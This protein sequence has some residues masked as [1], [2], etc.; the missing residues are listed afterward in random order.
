M[1]LYQIDHVAVS[2]RGWLNRLPAGVKLIA[3][4]VLIG[5][6]LWL[7]WA[8]PVIGVLAALLLA[9]LSARVPLRMLLPLTLYPIVFLLIIFLSTR[10]L[11]VEAALLITARVLAITCAVIMLVLSTPYPEIFGALSCFLPR[12]LIAALFFTYRALFTIS[13]SVHNIRIALHVRGSADWRRPVATLRQV[14]MALGHLMVNSI[15]A[16]ER[17]ADA[18]T[19]RGFQNRIYHLGKRHE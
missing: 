7:R 1:D 3:L 6:L 13:D 8:V 16:S 14:G 2:G 5:V 12:F 9:A 19:V 11:T 17:M 18:L 4:V 15:D 10:G